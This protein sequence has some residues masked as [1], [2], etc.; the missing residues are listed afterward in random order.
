[1]PS[2]PRSLARFFSA[3]IQKPSRKNHRS[4]TRRRISRAFLAEQL[5]DRRMLAS[6]TGVSFN[7]ANGDGVRNATEDVRSSVTVFLD[8]N[9]NGQ[10]D[11][12]EASTETDLNGQYTF[13]NLN[14][15]E[16]VVRQVVPEDTVTT[17]PL[18]DDAYYGF[19]YIPGS[20]GSMQSTRID[21]QNGDVRRLSPPS[22]NSL[23][24]L[25][26]TNDGEFFAIQ[27]FDPD[28]FFSVDF[29]TNQ[30]TAIGEIGSNAAFGLA[31]DPS[32][33]TIYGIVNDRADGRNKLA[34]FD[35][36]TGQ[37]TLLGP[38]TYELTA[39]SSLAFDTD[40]GV[41]VAFDNADDQFWQFDRAGTPSLLWDTAGLNGW[42]LAYNG[43]EFLLQAAG[44]SDGDSSL[45]NRLFYRIDPYHRSIRE[46]FFVASEAVPMDALDY[47]RADEAHL[48]YVA[49]S[50][51]LTNLDFGTTAPYGGVRGKTF[52]D[53]NGNGVRDQGEGV[54]AGV[55]VYLDL[56]DNGK[57]DQTGDGSTE[58]STVTDANGNYEFTDIPMGSHVIREVVPADYRQTFPT[59]GTSRLFATVLD[60]PGNEIREIDPQT[61]SLLNTF[62]IDGLRSFNTNGLAFDG[63]TLYALSSSGT[64]FEADPDDGTVLDTWQLPGG[65]WDGLA[66]LDG[67]VYA[68][69][70]VS[71]R[72]LVI[73]PATN[74]IVRDLDFAGNPNVAPFGGL[75][76]FTDAQGT[77]LLLGPIGSSSQIGLIDPQS[78]AVT[79]TMTHRAV[80]GRDLGLAGLSGEIYVGFD[81]IEGTIQ[82]FDAENSLRRTLQVGQR[83]TALAGAVVGDSA[84]RVEVR[85]GQTLI[86]LDFGNQSQLGEIHGRKFE[87][88]NGNGV[89]DQDDVPLAGVT[90]YLDTN[91]NGALDEGEL[92]TQTSADGSYS[93]VAIA[94]GDYVVREIVPRDF[95]QTAPSTEA[96]LFATNVGANPDLIVELDPITGDTLNSFTA[97]GNTNTAG[98]GIAFDGT[99]LYYVD[100]A[101]D[102]LYE[103]DPNDGSVRD[104]TRLPNGI[105]DGVAAID[106]LVYVM[107]TA[108]DD[109]LVFDPVTNRTVGVLDLNGLNPGYSFSGGIGESGDRTQLAV[110]TT[111]NQI[112]LIDP[113]TGVVTGSMNSTAGQSFAVTG[114]QDEIY[115]GFG[116]NGNV[117]VLDENGGLLRSINPAFPIYGLAGF[118]GD[119]SHRVTLEP[120]Q[121]LTGLDFGNQSLL[122][123]I[124]G[125]KFED[126]NGNGQ[127]D[128]DEGPL[129]GVTIFL[130]KNN[131]GVLDDDERSTTTDA[132][133]DY[134]FADLP[135]AD[136]IVRE[137]V[138]SG[139]AQTFPAI[140]E[141]R[142]FAT[143]V[144]ASPDAIIELDPDTGATL[145]S[146]PAPVNPN[147]GG[148]GLAF[149][150]T[151]LY[152]VDYINDRLFELDPEDGSVRDTTQ[153]P[154]GNYDGVA[155]LNGLIYISDYV[156]DDILV[157]DPTS[158]TIVD[159]LNINSLN[160]GV[161][162]QGGLGES[163]EGSHLV[164]S[165]V[166]SDVMLIDPRTGRVTS[167]FVN[168]ITANRFDGGAT[169]FNGE[170]YLGFAESSNTIVTFDNHGQRQRSINLGFPIY[171]LGGFAQD[172]GHHV[173]LLA[174]QMIEDLDFGNISIN[175]SPIADAGGPYT[176]NEGGTAILDGTGSWDPD[177]DALIYTW[178]LDG[179]GIFGETGSAALHGNEVGANPTYV[180]VGLDG[181]SSSQVALRVIDPLSAE[182]A[183]TTMVNIQN[184]APRVTAVTL[185]TPSIQENGTVTLT[186]T[187]DD[188]GILDTHDVVIDWGDGSPTTTVR[189][190]EK[191]RGFTAS[192]QYL[193]DAPSNSPFDDY[194]VTVQVTDD[195]GDRGTGETTITVVN[196]IPTIESL[197]G[198][199]TFTQPAS[200][201]DA[202]T[203]SGDFSD[204]GSL[205]THTATINW[206]DGTNS[207]ATIIQA[208]GTF[209][210][211]HDYGSAGVYEI[212]V[213]LSDDDSGTAVATTTAVVSGVGIVGDRLYVI[214]T[215]GDDHVTINQQGNG[216]IKVHADFLKSGKFVTVPA[217]DVR[218]IVAHL[219]DGDDFLSMAGN[220]ALPSILHGGAGDDQLKAGRG[221]AVLLGGAGNDE[222]QGG[223]GRNVIIGGLDEDRL[224]GGNDDDVL[225]GGSTNI[226]E[227][228]EAIWA[229]LA[230]WNSNASYDNR[231]AAIDSLLTVSDDSEEDEL[232]GHS[233]RDLFYQGLEDSLQDVKTKKDVEQVL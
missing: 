154:G 219:L 185:N 181:P 102:T 18:Y 142:L 42:G 148:H 17:T 217:Q 145:H 129:A 5:E 111:S 179:D 62:S 85:P 112:A 20:N 164:A 71:R 50:E 222:L 25:A 120:S 101:F 153:L 109:I 29:S 169:G 201:S 167:S 115:V 107:D 161:N 88:I 160:P 40:R 200:E 22:R 37:P 182:D 33:D 12:G 171:G 216:T 63:Q 190:S 178:D 87:D 14:T 92:S 132:S 76:E 79:G 221:P 232:K 43:D 122:G 45:L 186:G 227:D 119:G 147:T 231:V 157:F 210:A 213:T 91:N 141:A 72:I 149:D 211:D 84:H 77:N 57:L 104:S 58:P 198:T 170:I 32:T 3:S 39:T 98:H 35:R 31:Y 97:P 188:P 26:R 233:G 134:E 144:A 64:M 133:G 127:R 47:F 103:L 215:P 137:V 28:R 143:H 23:H 174:S 54:F 78:G 175:Q 121:V 83:V 7:D 193:D 49:E 136:Y 11:G 151:T 114:F 53:G 189:L 89:E 209:T 73:D 38:G 208:D 162:L 226:D 177:D 207:P 126:V 8:Q 93:F 90:I 110:T 96:R 80:N 224:K 105:F 146:F 59:Q 118:G 206:G 138:P 165:T 229:L 36:T 41:V 52:E 125:T 94:N 100:L 228:E 67:E 27:G 191:E 69:D 46:E 106:G 116:G 113:A 150:G 176:V 86:G 99:T 168:G 66:V 214:G 155:A 187:F 13:A 131:D 225:I 51:A 199:A 10:L 204:L 139:F 6:L 24:G 194:S 184:V 108:A 197:S 81:D 70:L 130:D 195:D 166:S 159:R 48:V 61:G 60:G 75:G 15:G 44:F 203:I 172:G 218:Q 124:Q 205:D 21:P 74:A 16:Y 220:I 223:G 196:A 192:H 202:V 55:T 68:N 212:T 65:R 156:L 34:T 173:S 4:R 30:H 230:T 117:R 56:N 1:M 158:N 152:Y 140:V 95:R 128:P 2:S 19:A 135:A 180:A 123:K 163:G 9:N 82:V 183:A